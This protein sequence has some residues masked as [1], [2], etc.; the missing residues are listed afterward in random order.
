MV[1]FG[2]GRYK[3]LR[4]FCVVKRL[5]RPCFG[6]VDAKGSDEVRHLREGS[7]GVSPEAGHHAF[8]VD[9]ALHG[10]VVVLVPMVVR[11]RFGVSR[12]VFDPCATGQRY[13]R[14]EVEWQ[15]AFV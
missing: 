6:D 12:R 8:Q 9:C 13:L 10:R 2:K 5:P 3:I 4:L 11:D 7:P 15:R 1:A 14:I